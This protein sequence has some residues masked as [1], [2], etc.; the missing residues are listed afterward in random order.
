M[1]DFYMNNQ[2]KI[3]R[4]FKTFEDYFEFCNDAFPN[5]VPCNLDEKIQ[6]FH[7]VILFKSVI[8]IK[9]SILHPGTFARVWMDQFSELSTIM[10]KIPSLENRKL[11][12]N[13]MRKLLHSILRT[14]DGKTEGKI[15]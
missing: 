3:L 9:R 15:D 11:N 1:N 14:Q 7:T 2:S 4:E 13:I 10:C 8:R 5:F 6:V 12:F